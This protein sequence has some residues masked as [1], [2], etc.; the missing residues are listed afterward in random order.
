MTGR[1]GWPAASLAICRSSVSLSTPGRA[2][3]AASSGSETAMT[4]FSVR[5][6]GWLGCWL[7][8]SVALPAQADPFFVRVYGRTYKIDPRYPSDEKGPKPQ[9]AMKALPADLAKGPGFRPSH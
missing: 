2:R 4:G 9:D 3:P 7:A 5:R 6:L 8:L 1:A